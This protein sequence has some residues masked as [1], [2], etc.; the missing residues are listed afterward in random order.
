MIPETSANNTVD[1]YKATSFPDKWEFVKHLIVGEKFVDSTVWA[2]GNDLYVL[3]Y[4]KQ[5]TGWLL[6]VYQFSGQDLMLVSSKV[7]SKNIGRPAG[8]IFIENGMRIRPAQDCSEKYGESL[9]LYCIDSFNDSGNYVEHE[10]GRVSIEEIK[11]D[12]AIDRIHTY[13]R[14]SEYEVIDGYREKFDLF[15]APRI[16]LRSR[17]K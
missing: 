10:V 9:I 16:F 15:H 1:L 6:C 3:T 11:V 17:R 4:K 13:S 8:H 2:E 12:A 7:Y 5:E 14:D